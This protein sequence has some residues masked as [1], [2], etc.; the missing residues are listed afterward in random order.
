MVLSTTS[1]DS[2]TRFLRIRGWI[3]PG[4]FLVDRVRLGGGRTATTVR[5]TT[6]AGATR[7]LRQP[8]AITHADG[9]HVMSPA[10]RLAVEGEFYSLIQP[11][12]AI[13]ERM[14]LCLG[15][16]RSDHIIALQ[17]LGTA[18]ALTDLYV[19]RLL[20]SDEVDDL[21]AY[22]VALHGISVHA[23]RLGALRG[24]GV[25][26]ARHADRFEHPMDAPR[27]DTLAGTH[28]RLHRQVD[29]I[30]T[31]VH[32]R[33]TMRDL[34]GRYLEGRGVLLHGDFRPARWMPS[35]HGLH[36]LAPAYATAG[37]AAF[38]LGFFVA[39]LLLAAQPHAIISDVLQRYRRA[40][41][42]DMADVSACVGLELIR[43]RL[44]ALPVPGDVAPARLEA[45]LDYA[46]RL[47]GGRAT[48]EL[49][50]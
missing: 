39:H 47:L 29:A 27:I 18:R 22:L 40:T 49:P 37:P 3:P 4:A 41:P 24:D 12:S 1:L 32:V 7:V 42:I 14:P 34:G 26:L 13:T 33:A 10:D 31:D 19:G 6:N 16:D 46:A 45:E 30:R 48:V 5:V 8:D 2:L 28:P 50:L 17:D 23:D 43:G 36:I 20:S 44:G 15:V 11:W 25:R 38:D 21:T 35:A 9:R